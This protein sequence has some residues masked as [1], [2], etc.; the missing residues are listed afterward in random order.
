MGA[1]FADWL[2][3]KDS[4]VKNASSLV[5]CTAVILSLADY[6]YARSSFDE[7]SAFLQKMGLYQGV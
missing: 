1:S 4:L 2:L 6:S 3:E 7:M 5:H